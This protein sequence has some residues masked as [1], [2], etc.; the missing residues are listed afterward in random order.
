MTATSTTGPLSPQTRRRVL[1]WGTAAFVTALIV[2]LQWSHVERLVATSGGR[3]V[4]LQA[5]LTGL[6]IGGVYGLVAMGLTLIFGVLE[7]INFAHGAFLTVGM[8][9]TYL[10][11]QQ[12]G[13]DP[14]LTLLVTPLVLLAFGAAVQKI[15]INPAMGQ[16]LENQ[17]LLTLGLAILIENV[18]LLLFTAT[19][20]SV[21]IPYAGTEVGPFDFPMRIGGAVLELPRILAF[22]GGIA[23]AGALFYFLN[24]T[25]IGTA[26]RAVGQ[27]PSGAQLVGIDVRR[28]Y[29]TTFGIG[30]AAAGAAGVLV[31]PFLT[32]EPTTGEQFNILAFV[33][34]VLGGLGNVVGALIGGIIIG[35][36]QEIGG[37]IFPGQSKLL[38]VFII[39]ILV[40]F[41]K[42]EGLF[43]RSR[44]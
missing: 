14:Y 24:R 37:L 5:I 40:L 29:V 42:P 32:L 38:P 16:P 17:L 1:R 11:V 30:S 36:T 3:T 19:P 21:R 8:Y 20:R 15:M 33:I 39:F 43:G 12:F 18:F 27:N 34:V 2:A 25:K 35:L 28:I 7:I 13:F 41:L 26:I 6:L 10:L 22:L 4:A 23:L 9:S 31:L 44:R